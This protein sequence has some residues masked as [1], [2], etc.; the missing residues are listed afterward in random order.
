MNFMNLHTH[1]V[2]QV[3]FSGRSH[4]SL[5]SYEESSAQVIK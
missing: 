3:K 5:K 2:T 1:I 4:C